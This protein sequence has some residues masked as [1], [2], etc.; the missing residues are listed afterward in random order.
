M[1][2][3]KRQLKK[4]IYVALTALDLYDGS[5]QARLSL[6]ED[7]EVDKGNVLAYR[8]VKTIKPRG[9][10]KMPEPMGQEANN[11][12][13]K[14]KTLKEEMETRK[15]KTEGLLKTASKRSEDLFDIFIDLVVVN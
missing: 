12:R 4:I 5:A 3:Q 11:F 13:E 2:T 9:D 8:P 7:M 1:M 14:A 15:K 10:E 6:W